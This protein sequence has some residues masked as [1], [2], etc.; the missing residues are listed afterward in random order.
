MSEDAVPSEYEV[1]MLEL[2]NDARLN[3][4]EILDS[5]QIEIGAQADNWASHG[6]RPLELN[7]KLYQSATDHVMDMFQ[8]GYF[9]R[10]SPDGSTVEDR[11]R[12]EGYDAVMVGETLGALLFGN[13]VS[14]RNA[15]TTMFRNMVKNDL[16]DEQG[17]G[18]I[19]SNAF[20]E[21]GISLKSGTFVM[22]GGERK[23]AYLVVCDFGR[24]ID[25][26][27]ARLD[28]AEKWLHTMVNEYRSMP[29]ALSGDEG[30]DV[31]SAFN[32]PPA[33]WPLSWDDHLE[34]G[35]TADALAGEEGQ[36]A[37]TEAQYTAIQT[38]NATLRM[39]NNVYF[40]MDSYSIAL[41]I[42][43]ALLNDETDPGA[44]GINGLLDPR[45]SA[46]R[47]SMDLTT[48]EDQVILSADIRLATPARF[49]PVMLGRVEGGADGESVWIVI[50]YPEKQ[51]DRIIIKEATDDEGFYQ[52]SL[53][54]GLSRMYLMAGEEKQFIKDLYFMG[55]HRNYVVDIDWSGLPEMGGR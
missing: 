42:F 31:Q 30:N 7:T 41:K 52:M 3:P 1:M 27:E 5:L 21:I 50:E 35:D 2:I 17:G 11:V 24:S 12:R 48:I 55:T 34:D 22:S 19:L 32:P 54:F 29:S 45:F 36:S 44:D 47:V 33:V 13:F 4:E 46:G 28:S 15:V 9:S 43:E 38:V 6:L 26:E 37:E 49:A 23:N 10:I 39:D 8:K 18:I 51:S 14:P 16:A 25:F 20:S 40:S 53:P